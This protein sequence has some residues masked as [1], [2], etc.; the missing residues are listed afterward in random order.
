MAYTGEAKREYQRNWI[1]NR[2]AEYFLEK[3]CA[4]CGSIEDLELDHIDPETKEYPPASLWSM[5]DGNPKKIAELAK[6][7]VLCEPCHLIKTLAAYPDR[8]HGTDAMWRKEG[9]RCPECKEYVRALKEQSRARL[10]M[11]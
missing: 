5:S 3:W 2:R 11:A 8:V 9:C 6:C 1:A 10:R 4:H 7:Q